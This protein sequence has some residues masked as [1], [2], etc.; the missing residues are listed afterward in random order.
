MAGLSD[1][2]VSNYMKIMMDTVEI[3]DIESFGG[4][5]E[6]T[7][8]VEVKQY[9]QKFARKLAASSTVGAV[10]L[11]CSFAPESASYKALA[12][13]KATDARKP[14]TVTYYNNAS[15]TEASERTFTGI[16]TSY[17]ESGEYDAQR[18]CTWT[19]AVDG[20]LGELKAVATPKA[21]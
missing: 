10:E 20:A 2:S 12:V 14:F 9:N 18:T 15:K 21:A 19:I 5:N 4:F 16:V 7:S 8:I 6:E 17:T 11:T 13:A 3:T 1:I